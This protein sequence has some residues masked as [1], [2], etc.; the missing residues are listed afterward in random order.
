MIAGGIIGT[1]AAAIA[2]LVRPGTTA[3]KKGRNLTGSWR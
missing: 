1:L 3:G 2:G